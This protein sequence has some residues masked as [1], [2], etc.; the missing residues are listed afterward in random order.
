MNLSE[1][2]YYAILNVSRDASKEEI[3]LAYRT[4]AI[5]LCPFRDAK[6]LRDFVPLSQENQLTHMAPLTHERQWMYI[7][8]AYDILGKL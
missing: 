5:R 7:N 3:A 8:M 1:L 2:D 4:L 6:H